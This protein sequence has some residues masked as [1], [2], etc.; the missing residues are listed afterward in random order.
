MNPVE[1][2]DLVLSQEI[3][4]I[5]LQLSLMWAPSFRDSGLFALSLGGKHPSMNLC[6]RTRHPTKVHLLQSG[7]HSNKELGAK[8]CSALGLTQRRDE[9]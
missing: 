4:Q 3:V 5:L 8:W 1:T 2:V 6:F 7:A 9:R